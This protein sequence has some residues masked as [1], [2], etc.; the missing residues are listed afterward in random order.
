MSIFLSIFKISKIFFLDK[1]Q[2]NWRIILWQFFPIQTKSLRIS[3]QSRV[4]HHFFF[5][6][7]LYCPK[8]LKIMTKLHRQNKEKNWF[9]NTF[10][11]KME[12]NLLLKIF[13]WNGPFRLTRFLP[14]KLKLEMW[15]DRCVRE[16]HSSENQY[17]Y[18]FVYHQRF[19]N[20]IHLACTQTIHELF[21]MFFAEILPQ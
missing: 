12:K 14:C 16:I 20:S 18:L 1:I 4:L 15:V 2:T 21:H 19:E 13:S 5:D 8:W 17:V 9:T 10:L 3:K 11:E 7:S 6:K